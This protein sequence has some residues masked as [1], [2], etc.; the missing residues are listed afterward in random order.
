M[1]MAV[2]VVFYKKNAFSM[3]WFCLQVR[4]SRGY[5]L[6]LCLLNILKFSAPVPLLDN[7]NFDFED[8]WNFKI[9][10]HSIPL[11]E[12]PK[13]NH[14]LPVV[15][16]TDEILKV[17]PLDAAEEEIV[18]A[19]RLPKKIHDVIRTKIP[20]GVCKLGVG[21]LQSHLKNGDSME[22]IKIKIVALCVTLKIETEAV[23][24][25]FVD[26]FG[27]ELVPAYNTSNLEPSKTCS[28][29]FG[30]S[31]GS[32]SNEIHE[33]D[34]ETP[35]NHLQAIE[36]KFPKVEVPTFKVLHLSD[37]HLDPDYAEGSPTN[38]EEPLCCRNYSTPSTNE[39]IIPAGRWGSYNKCDSPRILI[40]NMLK[41]ISLE[42][43]DIDYI[44]WTGDLPPHD[45]W[46]QTQQ[47]NLDIIK[48]SVEQM[49]RYFPNIPIFPAVGNHESVP[50]GSFAPPWIK[51]ETHT[52]GWL[53]T[54]LA[55]HWRKWLPSTSG[56]TLLHGA[57]YSVLLRPGFRLISLNTNYCHSLNWWLLVNSTDPADELKWL[58]HELENAEINNEKVHIIGHIP[59]GS[60][61]CLKTWSRNFYSIVDRFQHT[62]TAQF[63]GHTHADEFELFYETNN[64]SRPINVAYLGPSITTYENN[65]P[66]FRIYYV[67]GDHERST[68]AVIDHETWTTNLD[69]ANEGDNEPIWYKLYTAKD[70]YRLS[71]LH[72][73]EWNRLIKNMADDPDLF[74]LFY[75]NYYR[76]SSHRPY[77]D[78]QCRIQ[79]LCDL[80]T[81]KSQDRLHLCNELQYA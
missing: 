24:T 76:D 59:P 25:G 57:F 4:C 21:L 39:T 27:P 7:E 13:E 30:E 50:A 33:W 28:M 8:T 45:I 60:S 26:V 20:C 42:H 23:C 62:I 29:I 74:N 17:E 46:N 61:D 52:I 18:G 56:N 1:K 51:N 12:S 80:K 15:Y 36:E 2:S 44:I 55:D 34:I 43:P 64:Y 48:E 63:Y 68:R 37:T 9:A 67:E 47:S 22:E 5:L 53:Y 58:V 31:C 75:R 71:S 10:P 19:N 77:C 35:E 73:E 32:V 72:P 41:F 70:A 16:E 65:N 40:E 3:D 81:G 14:I 78:A 38:C 11:L 69:L 79:I 49:L 54:N 66:A 6:G